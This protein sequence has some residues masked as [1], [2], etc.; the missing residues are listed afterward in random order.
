MQNFQHIPIPKKPTKKSKERWDFRPTDLEI[1]EVQ[2]LFDND[3]N[4]PENFRQTAPPH[5]AE[6]TIE[7]LPSLYY[8]YVDKSI[9]DRRKGG[10]SP[11]TQEP[12]PKETN[13]FLFF[14]NPQTTEFCQKLTIQDFNLMLCQHP[15]RGQLNGEPH[16]LIEERAK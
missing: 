2:E 12:P 5:K 3:F 7:N 11:N 9:R 15:R 6:D 13:F 16:Y 10:S 14:R 1:S 8:Q 4:I